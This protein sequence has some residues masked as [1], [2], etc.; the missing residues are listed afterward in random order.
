M[1]SLFLWVHI[2][3]CLMSGK[4]SFITVIHHC[5]IL[6]SFCMPLGD[7]WPLQVVHNTKVPFIEEHSIVFCFLSIFHLCVSLCLSHCYTLV[8]KHH[9]Q[10]NYYFFKV[11]KINYWGLAYSLEVCYTIIMVGS[12]HHASGLWNNNWDLHPGP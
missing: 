11:K 5:H 1:L 2:C 7:L 9:N 6:Q 3:N 8:K 10:V 4:C 12:W